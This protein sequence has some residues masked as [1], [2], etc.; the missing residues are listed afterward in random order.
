MKMVKRIQLPSHQQVNG[1][2]AMAEEYI[3]EGDD[4]SMVFNLQD[5]VD[6]AVSDVTIVSSKPAQNG[7]VSM[8]PTPPPSANVMTFPGSAGSFRTDTEIS[9]QRE[10][11]MLRER[12]LQPWV[13]DSDPGVDLSLESAAGE[14]GWDQFAANEAMYGVQ[15]TYDEN[16][17]TTEIDRSNPAYRQQEARAA[18]I[19]REI[20]GSAPANAHVAEERR[21]EAAAGS[22]MDEEEKYSGVRRDVPDLPKG[23]AGSYVPPS[24]RPITNAPT[25]PG[26]P[27]DPAI[28]SLEKP[29]AKSQAPTAPEGYQ[30]KPAPEEE[31]KEPK[32]A[33]PAVNAGSQARK[34]GDHS[35]EDHMRAAADSFKQFANS[36]KLRIRQAQ[37]QKRAGARH[38]KNVKLNDLK[39]FAAS[40]Q[41]KSRVPDDLVPILAKDVEKQQDIQRKA[42]EAARAAETRSKAREG[43]VGTSAKATPN[44]AVPS[45]S[46]SDPR[47]LAHNRN[48]S[49]QA[50]AGPQPG[51]SQPLLTREQ[52]IEKNTALFNSKMS[53]RRM[54]QQIPTDLRIPKAPAA[55]NQNQ[56]QNQRPPQSFAQPQAPAQESGPLSPASATR[57]NVN[58]KSFE[59]RPNPVANEFTPTGTSPSPQRKLSNQQNDKTV[60]T[61]PKL[62]KSKNK[63]AE[64]ESQ[65]DVPENT[66]GRLTTEPAEEQKK[67]PVY[68][69]NG[70]IPPAY[71]TAPTW[72]TP[73]DRKASYL[74]LF[75]RGRQTSQGPSMMH[76][77]DPNAQMPHAHQ[78]PPHMQGPPQ[79]G[80]PQSAPRFYQ[81]PQH[82]MPHFAPGMGQFGPNGSVQSSPRFPPAQ[83]AYNAQMQP[84]MGM[85]QYPG[86]SMPNF[87]MSPGMQYRQMNMPQGNQG[88][89]MQGP[90]HGSSKYHAKSKPKPN[91]NRAGPADRAQ[92]PPQMRQNFPNQG[93][94]PP[95]FG[96]PG[97]GGQMMVQQSSGGYMGGP[98]PQQQQQ[99]SPMPQHPQ[100]HFQGGPPHH[101]QPGNPPYAN[102][103]RPHPTSHQGSHQGY[104]PQQQQ[105]QQGGPGMPPMGGMQ[106]GFGAPSPGQH[107]LP[108]PHPYHMQQRQMSNQG[109]TPRGQNAMPMGMQQQ[110]SQQQSGYPGKGASHQAPGLSQGGDEGK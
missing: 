48:R 38:E 56:I 88:M 11:Q 86:P 41:L 100:P 8:L 47:M 10:R 36:E 97:M 93:P 84:Q 4:H 15:S 95:H 23:G 12:E 5:T 108:Q 78:L 25:V 37:E 66:V 13:P 91:N 14:G 85:P 53:A 33:V 44:A 35:A 72:A 98:M 99:Y 59:F 73:E 61:L 62:F 50:P 65:E 82:N 87:G 21:R 6:L 49:N 46:T 68:K 32:A 80:T 77:P 83:M 22:G 7:T 109:Y 110:Q 57:L 19:A 103:P 104:Q 81:Q 67:I 24:R 51:S 71:K 92:V 45:N 28:I 102:S 52:R 17:Y 2:S 27:Y 55:L 29:V 79:M 16:I 63:P 69:N 101:M 70:G 96:S 105:Q 31:K 40:F 90:P 39:K 18:R 42:E 3:G 89:M 34:S 20:E 107:G 58:A 75:P 54:P 94:P 64:N 106:G 74:E 43:E 60:A 76:A 9:S 30:P 1:N 26:A